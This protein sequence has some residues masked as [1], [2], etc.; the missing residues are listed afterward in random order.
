MGGTSTLYQK[1]N[2]VRYKQRLLSPGQELHEEG[3]MDGPT[4]PSP[5]SG[6]QFPAPAF[7]CLQFLCCPAEGACACPSPLCTKRMVAG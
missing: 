2:K 6:I 3:A 7:S 1:R 4:H 5:C